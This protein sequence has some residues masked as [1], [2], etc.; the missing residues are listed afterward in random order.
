MRRDQGGDRG[1]EGTL[2]A[3]VRNSVRP[4]ATRAAGASSGTCSEALD[5]SNE[6]RSLL[7]LAR[8]IN[9]HP[10]RLEETMLT[11]GAHPSTQTLTTILTTAYLAH[12]TSASSTADAQPLLL[13][14][15][16][17]NASRD[18]RPRPL[19]YRSPPTFLGTPGHQS[20]WGGDVQ[21]LPCS[22]AEPLFFFEKPSRNSPLL[23]NELR[24]D[25]PL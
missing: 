24:V 21:G 3:A 19:N 12:D 5:C 20:A 17:F 4:T 6:K 1:I 9:V 11:H 7:R 18:Q 23:T 16:A 25:D 22:T 8:D 10:I 13:H 14:S 15:K 2:T